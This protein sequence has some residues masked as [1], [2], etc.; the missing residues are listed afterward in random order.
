MPDIAILVTDGY[1]NINEQN[2]VP[3]ANRAKDDRT[4]EYERHIVALQKLKTPL[5]L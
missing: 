2:T 4:G 1:S 5:L 3:E